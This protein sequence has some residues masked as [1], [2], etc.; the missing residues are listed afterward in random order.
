[1]VVAGP[2]AESWAD[3]SV[4]FV[5][6]VPGAGAAELTVNGGPA[7][8]GTIGFGQISSYF[9]VSAGSHEISLKSGSKT[10]A[11]A[12]V[13]L[14][15][16]QRYTIVAMA[17]GKKAQLRPYTD[18]APRPGKARIRMIHAAPEL[19]SPDVRLGKRPIAEEVSYTAATPYLTVSPGTYTLEVMKPGDGSGKPIVE[20]PG[21][22]LSA[23]TTSTAFLLGSRGEATR[24]VVASDGTSSP[25]GA[26]K[27]GLAPLASGGRPWAAILGIA[28]LAGLLGGTLQLVAARRRTRAR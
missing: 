27:T 19:G 28:L 6:A 22:A 16:G 3:A 12:H 1:M 23:G 8:G 9:G 17:Q 24:V 10:G 5:N 13:D 14:V 20:K 25:A 18:G 2:A 21:V 15:N 4:R 11:T 7:V 26:P